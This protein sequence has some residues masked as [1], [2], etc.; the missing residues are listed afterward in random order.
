[1]RQEGSGDDDLLLVPAAQRRN[2]VFRI[3]NL[4][5]DVA[6]LSGDRLAFFSLREKEPGQVVFKAGED[7]IPGNGHCLNQTFSLTVFRDE[8]NS[9]GDPVFDRT[10]RQF[11]TLQIDF[12][13]RFL[14]A[15]GQAFE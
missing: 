6:D 14:R 13:G 4:D 8:D 1:M 15:A 3:G 5:P 2:Q 7:D 9:V 12:A 10:A 11:S